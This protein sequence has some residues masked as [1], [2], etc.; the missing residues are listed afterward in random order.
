MRFSRVRGANIWHREVARKRDLKKEALMKRII[1]AVATVCFAAV[2]SISTGCGD[3]FWQGEKPAPAPAPKAQDFCIADD[4]KPVNCDDGNPC[5]T[6]KCAVAAGKAACVSTPNTA[7]CDD[8]NPCTTGDWCAV[9]ACQSG[10][11]INCDDGNPCTTDKCAVTAGK[12]A[13]VSTPNTAVCDDGNLCTVKDACKDGAC[14]GGFA[15]DCD[16]GISCTVDSCD[17]ATGCKHT[18]D[19][20]VCDDGN[21]CTDDSCDKVK[22]CQY[23]YNKKACDDGNPCTNDVCSG[24]AC[25]GT[26]NTAACDD[27]NV[28]TQ[29]DQCKAGACVGGSSLQCDDANAC[30]DD[31]CDAVKGCVFK[32]NTK[33]CDDGNP[34]TSDV[35]SGGD[36]KGTPNTAA[37]DD[38]NVCTQ[39]DK[40]KDGVCAGVAVGQVFCDDGN[41][42]TVDSCDPASGCV[43]KPAVASPPFVCDDGNPCTV[44]DKCFGGKCVAGPAMDCD[45]GNSCTV[46]SCNS[47]SGVCKHT[48]NTAACDDGDTNTTSDQCKAG[49]CAGMVK[50]SGGCKTASDCVAFDDGNACNGVAVC[51]GGLCGLTAP[52][53]CAPSSACTTSTCD[54][55][56]GACK[57]GQGANMKPCDD[58]NAC[59][60]GDVCVN[61]ACKGEVVNCDDGNP[62]TDHACKAGVCVHTP[63]AA[64]CDDGNACTSGDKCSSGKCA[65][66]ANAC[67]CQT[68]SDCASLE[69]G[70]ACNGTLVCSQGH[71]CVV[72]PKTV[73]SC[74]AT[75]DTACAGNVCD[76]ST[77]KC[78]L[79][80]ANAGAK[81]NDND[82]CTSGDVCSGGKCAGDMISCDDANPCTDDACD[83]KKGCAHV[84]NTAPCDDGNALTTGDACKAGKCVGTLAAVECAKDYD[85]DDALFCNGAEKCVLGLCKPGIKPNC[86]DGIACTTDKCVEAVDPSGNHCQHTPLDSF[87]PSGQFCHAAVYWYEVQGCV[88]CEKDSDCDDKN[89]CTDDSCNAKSG[90]C[91]HKALTSTSWGLPA[92]SDGN[93]CTTG[94]ACKDGAC[95]GEAVNCDDGNPCT[96]DACDPAKGCTHAN[97]TATCDDGN[98]CTSADTCSGGAC[99][100]ATVNADD[101]NACTLD[102]CDKWSGVWHKV[103]NCDDSNACTTDVCDAAK[104]C[105]Y[106]P[107]TVPCS[108]GNACTTGDACKNGFCAGGATLSCDDADPCTLDACD[109]KVGCSHAKIAGCPAP[110]PA[111]APWAVSIS[112]ELPAGAMAE[113][114]VFFADTV[115]PAT[116]AAEKLGMSPFSLSLGQVEACIWGI[117]IAAR[118]PSGTWPWYGCDAGTP[119]LTSLTVKVNGVVK[120]GVLTKHPW[121]CGG[122]G[123]GNLAFTPVQLGCP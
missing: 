96:N 9:G 98:A 18:A 28:C 48:P 103:V 47:A 89:P 73:V 94:D 27:G 71:K 12:A 19:N 117:E 31:S 68:A 69:D 111:P 1:T 29:G 121:A 80:P 10:A 60:S 45:D 51:K 17:P 63:N 77:G 99:K 85:C 41:P 107:N 114:H 82:A 118:V 104:G 52:V 84:N 22:G 59:T 119:S 81:C 58:G 113:V 46:D 72:D 120:T 61:G 74:S 70:N 83:P 65:S 93:A 75:Q 7:A 33:P 5:T 37:C 102:Y 112:V 25:K 42:C 15:A 105:V 39:G 79:V 50:Q 57:E 23:A 56:T 55:A 66:G 110:P 54:P 116:K 32:P 53:V 34:C 88:A 76:P 95:K 122:A 91:E 35:C 4:G 30:T 106:I 6:D 20:T 24:G 43:H 123:E 90:V 49:A 108:D 8:G 115:A 14:A 40:C 100:G 21:A 11:P 38:G 62:C 13:C 109:P 86:D 92:C 2:L 16:D 78:A 44:D 67:E 87:C 64:A 3:E 36:C 26:P 101:G 97:N